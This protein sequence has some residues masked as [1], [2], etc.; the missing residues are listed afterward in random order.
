MPRAPRPFS[1]RLLGARRPVT[2]IRNV[3]VDVF[4]DPTPGAGQRV[5]IFA[6][7]ACG[8]LVA[9]VNPPGVGVTLWPFDPGVAIPAGSSLSV[10]VAGAVQ[11]EVYADGYTVPAA[12][13]PATLPA[14]TTGVQRQ[15]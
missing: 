4:T 8:I 14:H 6:G 11:A 10:N 3:K 15:H 1:L 9:D 12:A 2:I 13:V 7:N 5:D